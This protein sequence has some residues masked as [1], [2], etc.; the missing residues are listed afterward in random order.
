MS[1]GL[2]NEVNISWELSNVKAILGKASQL[3]SWLGANHEQVTIA[4][5]LVAGLYVLVEYRSNE[6]DATIKRAMEFQ[7]RY[8][9]AEILSSRMKLENYWLS[10]ESESD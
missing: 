9:Q 10:P 3:W 1:S 5:A 6:T 8:G 2:P 4:F 7:A